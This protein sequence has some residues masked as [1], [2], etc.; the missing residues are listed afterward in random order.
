VDFDLRRIDRVR[1]TRKKDRYRNAEKRDMIKPF[2]ISQ[3]TCPLATY[4]KAT[5]ARQFQPR[6]Y[7]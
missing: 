2:V 5:K 3:A 1:Q 7:R 6:L 4:K